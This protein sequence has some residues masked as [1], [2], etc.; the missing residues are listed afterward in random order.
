MIIFLNIWSHRNK[1]IF[2][3]ICPSP[4]LVL[5]FSYK[6]FRD[7]SYYNQN[8]NIQSIDMSDCKKSHKKFNH[9]DGLH[10]QQEAIILM[11]MH[12]N[13]KQRGDYWRCCRD[14]KGMTDITFG[15]PISDIPIHVMECMAI[16]FET[17]LAKSRKIRT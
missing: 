5:N 13:I 6:S 3:N 4:P 14:D 9:K 15:R 17:R 1:I 11:W 10:L 16:C 8:L 2:E 12:P 7:L